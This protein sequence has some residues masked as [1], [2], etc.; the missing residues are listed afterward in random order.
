MQIL[1]LKLTYQKS[2]DETLYQQYGKS[3]EDLKRQFWQVEAEGR[4]IE[5]GFNEDRISDYRRYDF[6]KD[7]AADFYLYKIHGSL[8]WCRDGESRLAFVDGVQTIDPQKME[9]IFGVQNKLQSYDPFNFYFYTFWEANFT[10]EL[11]YSK[12]IWLF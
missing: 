5:R 3:E 12:W 4:R 2:K 6:Q 1:S 9:I 8:H 11:I 10:A 7:D